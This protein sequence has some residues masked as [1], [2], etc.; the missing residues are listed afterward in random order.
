[1]SIRQL[2]SQLQE[3]VLSTPDGGVTRPYG[4]AASDASQPLRAMMVCGRSDPPM[5]NGPT[6]DQVMDQIENE[7]IERRAQNY[8]RDLR[9][10]AIVEYN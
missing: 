10:D 8:L 3:M 2:P 4:V 1:M 5:L 9:R 6:F 7:R